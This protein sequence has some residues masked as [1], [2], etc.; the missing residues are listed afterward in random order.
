MNFEL[1]TLDWLE[2]IFQHRVGVEYYK[3]KFMGL[4]LDL[5]IVFESEGL[6]LNK[7]EV[8]GLILLNFN[9]SLVKLCL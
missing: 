1:T 3:C 2:K 9:G 4:G 7:F 8:E 6:K 5:K